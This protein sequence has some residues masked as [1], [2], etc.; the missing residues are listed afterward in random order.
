MNPSKR[1]IILLNLCWFV[2]LYG[3]I[4]AANYGMLE[5]IAT[6]AKTIPWFDKFGHFILYGG[7]AFLS[8]LSLNKTYFCLREWRITE[9]MLL[10]LL[11]V[12]DVEVLA[13]LV[14]GIIIVVSCCCFSSLLITFRLLDVNIS[15]SS[16]FVLSSSSQSS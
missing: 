9:G 12:V 6:L 2:V 15:P 16:I 13:I 3:I 8:S 4:V 7:L 5:F 11:L 1:M 14:E 10:V